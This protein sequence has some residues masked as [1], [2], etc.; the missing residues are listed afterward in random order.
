MLALPYTPESGSS[1]QARGSISG[2]VNVAS[3]SACLEVLVRV[4]MP[5][6]NFIIKEEV[7]RFIEEYQMSFCGFKVADREVD[8]KISSSWICTYVCSHV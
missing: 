4:L 8:C 6:K 1:N 3:T 5:L 2:K 7:L